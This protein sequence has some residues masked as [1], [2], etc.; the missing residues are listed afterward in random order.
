MANRL[1]VK[2]AQHRHVLGPSG[3]DHAAPPPDK[4]WVPRTARFRAHDD[5]DDDTESVDT[6]SAR[7]SR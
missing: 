4:V 3:R 7:F 5:D 1:V 2:P 6:D